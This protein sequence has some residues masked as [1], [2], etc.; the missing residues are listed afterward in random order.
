M[1][2]T[3][4]LEDGYEDV[5]G[6]AAAGLGIGLAELS[7]KAGIPAGRVSS[8]MKGHFNEGDCLAVASVLGLHGPALVELAKGAWHPGPIEVDGLLPYTTPFPV[9]GYEEMTVNSY[10]VHD[11]GSG[12]AAAFDT[13][14]D[15]EAML[16]DV[17]RLGLKLEQVFLTH[18]H[19]DHIQALD[20]LLEETDSPQVW[21]H[22]NEPLAGFNH[23]AEGRVFRVG[24]LEIETRLTHGHSPGGTSYVISG[25]S[26]PVAIVGDSL[27]CCSQG[28][29]SHAYQRALENNRKKLLSLPPETVLCPGHGPMTTVLMEKQHNPFFPELKPG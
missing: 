28:G 23:F 9:P 6:K 17:E 12:T 15:V 22:E 16:A 7:G 29:A 14:S 8:L 21:V 2:F 10:L 20:T 3:A 25:L 26:R 1:N 4:R 11:T 18:S 19:G 13:G 27:F 5:V 24:K